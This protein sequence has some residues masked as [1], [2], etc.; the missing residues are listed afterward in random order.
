MISIT[1][2]SLSSIFCRVNLCPRSISHL[3]GRSCRSVTNLD[4]LIC[5]Y[6]PLVPLVECEFWFGVWAHQMD[7][8]LRVSSFSLLPCIWLKEQ[9]SQIVRLGEQR[10]D[11]TFF[12]FFLL[13]CLFSVFV[14]PPLLCPLII[15]TTG[16]QWTGDFLWRLA[17]F[18]KSNAFSGR[19]TDGGQ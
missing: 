1:R 6:L 17:N 15:S 3:I 12:S 4:L 13:C 8:T 9:L 11:L 19:S 7:L 18:E 16:L 2:E 5:W 14:P 10:S